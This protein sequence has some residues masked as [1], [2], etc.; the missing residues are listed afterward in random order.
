MAVRETKVEFAQVIRPIIIR[1]PI[2][3]GI[4]LIIWVTLLINVSVKEK[5]FRDLEAKTSVLASNP[6]EI[7][8]ISSERAGLEKKVKL[9]DELSSRKFF[10][11]EKL[12]Q[13][14]TIIPNGIWLTEVYSKAGPKNANGIGEKT[15]FIIRGIAVAYKIDDAVALI[16]DF[17]KKLQAD[18]NFSKDFS[19]IKLNTVSKGSVG[20]LDVMRFDFLCESK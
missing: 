4:S 13:V 5:I 17:I 18:Q 9:I 1:S 15:L 11:F 10:W 14:G 19:D 16:G 12:N 20:G 8:K 2:V 6:K 7:E 3:L